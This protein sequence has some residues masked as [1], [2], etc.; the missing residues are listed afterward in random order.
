LTGQARWPADP[1]A[2][3]TYG[4]LVRYEGLRVDAETR[5]RYAIRCI[6]VTTQSGM[7]NIARMY[8]EDPET[9]DRLQDA[10]LARGNALLNALEDNRTLSSELLNVL[11]T[12]RTAL[13]G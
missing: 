9:L 3:G 4:G 7:A 1:I 5:D 2:V 11:R 10:T 13:A 6:V 8:R 12:A